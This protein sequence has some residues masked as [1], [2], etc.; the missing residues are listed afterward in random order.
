MNMKQKEEVRVYEP[1]V[2]EVL[3]VQPEKGFA[4][5]GYNL[6]DLIDKGDF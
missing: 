2:L 1:P 5:T 6:D 4:V 3:N